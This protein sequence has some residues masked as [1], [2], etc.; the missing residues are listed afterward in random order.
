MEK[1]KK[2]VQKEHDQKQLGPQLQMY[3]LYSACNHT[4][5]T[6]AH[7]LRGLLV[8]YFLIKLRRDISKLQHSKD[9]QPA[10]KTN[11]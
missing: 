6:L 10:N 8:H 9:R 1:K 11:N 7:F 3:L 2:T 5:N 4:I